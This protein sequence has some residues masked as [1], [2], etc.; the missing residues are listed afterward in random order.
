MYT[1]DT[2]QLAKLSAK[3]GR[4]PTLIPQSFVQFFL[5]K[6]SSTVPGRVCGDCRIALD[7]Q[8]RR[9]IGSNRY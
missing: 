5:K 6:V 3:R 4:E 7:T 9:M 8:S 2:S 1:R